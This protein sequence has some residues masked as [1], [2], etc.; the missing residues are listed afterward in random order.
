[1][2]KIIFLGL[3]VGLAAG[4]D[5]QKPGAVIDVLHYEFG[6]TLTDADNNIRGNAVVDF[7][8]AKATN[9][10]T[11]DLITKKPNGKGMA[12]IAVKEKEQSLTFTH[13]NDELTI[14][15]PAKAGEKKSLT[16][17]YEGIPADGLIITNN[18]YK[19]R[20]FFWRQLAQSCAQLASLR[21]SSGR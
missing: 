1:M 20:G 17:Q 7:S 16:I 14:N 8:V 19:H 18:K 13:T 4:V 12:V 5:A 2:R 6:L 10:I 15:L 11:L 9:S 3:L 21:G